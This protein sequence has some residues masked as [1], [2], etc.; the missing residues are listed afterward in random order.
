MRLFVSEFITSGGLRDEPLA[1]PLL[2]EGRAMLL[3]LIADSA[4]I[5]GLTV[6]TTWDDR[7][8][9]PEFAGVEVIPVRTRAEYDQRILDLAAECDRSLLIAPECDGIL[10]TQI[11]L[12]SR[13]CHGTE[14]LNASREAVALCGDK[15]R[16][17]RFL[18]DTSISIPATESLNDASIDLPFENHVIKP[19]DG[20]GCESTFRLREQTP[21]DLLGSSI[22]TDRWILQPWIDG[23]ALSSAA[24]VSATGVTILPLGRQFVAGETQLAYSGGEIPWQ[25]EFADEA[26]AEARRLIREILAVIP[27]LRGWVGFDWVWSTAEHRLVLIE[28]NPRMTTSYLGYRRLFGF[29]LCA[30]LLGLGK[31]GPLPISQETIRFAKDSTGIAVTSESR[32]REPVR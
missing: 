25:G 17:S 21:R 24:I 10:E 29:N 14:R 28:I 15:L 30:V 5:E 23:P 12:V 16:L 32:D 31:V 19:R 1:T 4:A 11:E 26:N 13:I 7:L 2:A 6:V 18:S 27:G 20:A 3:A 9:R 8:P 22:H